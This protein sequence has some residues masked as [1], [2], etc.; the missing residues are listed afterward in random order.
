MKHPFQNLNQQGVGHYVVP[1]L[2]FILL[3]GIGGS[4]FYVRGH[5]ASN[6]TYQVITGPGGKCL[7]NAKNKKA[8]YNK[9]Q[10]FGCNQTA[11]QR[12]TVNAGK[13]AAGTIINSNGYCLDV[14][15]A[16]TKNYTKVDLFPCNNTVA[17]QWLLVGSTIKNPHS[18]L[19][20]D[21]YHDL[22]KN[23]NQIDIFKCNGTNAQNWTIKANGGSGGNPNPAQ[24][25]SPTPPPPS[26][27]G[28]GSGSGSGTATLG[29]APAAS[30]TMT[31][32]VSHKCDF[33]DTTNTGASGTLNSV[34]SGPTASTGHGWSV[35]GDTINVSAGGLLE[36]VNTGG[37]VV[38][39]NGANAVVKNVKIVAAATDV[40]GVGLRG[41]NSA[42]IENCT[43]AGTNGGSGRMMAGI[44]DY[45]SGNTYSANVNLTANNIYYTSTGIQVDHG[46]VQNNYVHDMGFQN[47]DHLNGFTSNGGDDNVLLTIQHNTMLNQNSQTDAIS[48]F[49]DFGVQQNRVIND[50]LVAGGGYT[51]YGGQNSGGPK[52]NHIKITNNHFS[53]M[54]FKTYGYYGYLAAYN[55]GGTGD[56]WSGNIDDTS[57]AAISD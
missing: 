46:M 52:T 42:V 11:A 20:L 18:G 5:A 32:T 25:P 47:G 54:F 50:N 4:Y 27:G 13:T 26:G 35:S 21:D 22:T 45:E 1:V 15:H 38:S 2:V 10:L 43:I 41:A 16:G 12:W 34:G 57:G 23:G 37:K 39:V 48:L 33:P 44:K 9:I 53:K 28:T 51:I 6:T 56:V 36:N 8:Q 31:N 29:C 40:A 14:Y 55:P 3:F 19:C 30:A 49:E 7:D 24:T 17:Q